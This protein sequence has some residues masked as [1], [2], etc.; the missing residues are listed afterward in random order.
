[1]WDK[2][3]QELALNAIPGAAGLLRRGAEEYF[4]LVCD[5][6][7]ASVPYK[8]SGRWELG[9]F[10]PA[11]KG[12]YMGLLKKGRK[13]ANSWNDRETVE[14]LSEIGS[15]AGEVFGRT[16]MEQWAVNASVHYN[17]WANLS[18]ADFRPVVEA[19]QDLFALFLCTDCRSMLR[20]ATTGNIPA[21]V[22]CNCGTV[23]WSLIEKD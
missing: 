23:R 7:Q 18:A 19:F 12:Q 1:M 10:L 8:L 9:D 14:T 13:A 11:A 6:L 17:N 5:A 21:A 2:I 3:E 4:A 22:G 15:V 16:Q 20:I